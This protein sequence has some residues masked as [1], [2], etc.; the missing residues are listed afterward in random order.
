MRLSVIAERVL[1]ET[2]DAV[3]YADCDGIIKVW[4]GGCERIFG[5]TEEE[6]VG[7]TL[8]I[9]IPEKLRARHW[10]GYAETMRT[11]QTRYGAGELLSVPAITKDGSRISV[12]FSITPISAPNG[13]MEG[14]AA[15]MRDVTETFEELKR[16]RARLAEAKS[17]GA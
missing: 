4:N 9:I 14:I 8:D 5:F 6:A 11:G 7:Q 17:A 16:L 15:T 10:Q 12:E 1:L 3:L 2:P 13:D